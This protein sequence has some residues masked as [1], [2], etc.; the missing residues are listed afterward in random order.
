MT[1]EGEA[2]VYTDEFDVGKMQSSYARCVTDLEGY[3]QQCQA[4][5]DDRRNE[6]AGK[7]ADRKKGGP[8]AF[9][10][11]GASDQHFVCEQPVGFL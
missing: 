11:V 9:P 3:F 1:T 5:Y 10:W 7:S 4:A 2:A 8:A 6:W